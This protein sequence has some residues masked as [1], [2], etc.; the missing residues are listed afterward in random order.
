MA[1]GNFVNFTASELP[2]AGGAGSPMATGNFVNFTP[3]VVPIPTGAGGPPGKG[4]IGL[5]ASAA[6]YAIATA[7]CSRLYSQMCQALAAS[8]APRGTKRHVFGGAAAG[9]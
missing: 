4:R 7:H 2:E 1:T 3:P 5:L 6:P 8:A 9:G